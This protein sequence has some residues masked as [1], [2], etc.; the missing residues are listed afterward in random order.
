MIVYDKMWQ[1]LEDVFSSTNINKGFRNNQLYRNYCC[2]F[3]LIVSTFAVLDN[4]MR[5]K[6]EETLANKQA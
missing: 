3:P 5:I 6:K 1:V 2:S 4:S